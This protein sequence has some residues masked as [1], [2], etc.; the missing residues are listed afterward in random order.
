M[1]QQFINLHLDRC[2]NGSLPPPPPSST[3]PAPTL[4]HQGVT[5]ERKSS[6][7]PLPSY[8]FNVMNPKELRKKAK[9]WGL[10]TYGSRNA[11]IARLKEFKLRYKAQMDSLDPKTSE[12][13]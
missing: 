4:T 2:L 11:L 12:F 5:Y 7:P 10:P 13:W 8:V 3:T 6:L 1:Q 9:D